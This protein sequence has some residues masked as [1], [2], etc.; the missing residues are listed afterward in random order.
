MTTTTPIT[1]KKPKLRAVPSPAPKVRKPRAP[2]TR[3]AVVGDKAQQGGKRFS[4]GLPYERLIRRLSNEYS[5]EMDSRVSE[6]CLV[7]I[8]IDMVRAAAKDAVVK[9]IVQDRA[10]H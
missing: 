7:R 1:S 3:S 4:I 9:A 6:T 5:I 8:G 10:T 2:K